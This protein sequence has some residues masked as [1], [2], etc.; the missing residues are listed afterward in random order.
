MGIFSIRLF[1]FGL[2]LSSAA[3][4]ADDSALAAIKNDAKVV[5]DKAKDGAKQVASAAKSVAHEVAAASKQGAQ[6]V[7]ATAKQGAEKAKA[8]VTG[9]KAIAPPAHPPAQ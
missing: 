5:A 2:I 8:A 7:A 6:Q 1:A 4:H 9:E 3:V